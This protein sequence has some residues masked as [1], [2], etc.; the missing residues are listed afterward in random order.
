MSIKSIAFNFEAS[1]DMITIS[2]DEGEQSF[3]V[4]YETMELGRM[5]RPQLLSREIAVTGAWV[6]PEK[7]IVKILY[8]ET[9]HDIK[10]TF[11]FDG[12]ELLWDTDINV[13]Y[14][15]TNLEQLKGSVR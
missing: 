7:Y 5:I 3:N 4:G 8:Y 11:R 12:D 1:P 15:P 2:S 14:G 9:P 6:S 13:S 10:F